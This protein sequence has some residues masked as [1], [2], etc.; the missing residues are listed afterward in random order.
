MQNDQYIEDIE[1]NSNKNK[2]CS[3]VNL[4]DVKNVT[5]DKENINLCPKRRCQII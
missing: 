5:K 4:N 2:V 3:N 1:K